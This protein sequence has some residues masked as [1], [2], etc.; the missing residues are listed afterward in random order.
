MRDHRLVIVV[1]LAVLTPAAAARVLAQ[2]PPPGAAAAPLKR[3]LADRSDRRL[4]QRFVEDAAVSSGGWVEMQ[5]RYENLENGSQHLLGPLV[6]FKIVNDVEGGLRFGWQDLN[7]DSGP[8]ESGLSDIDLFGK[9]RFQGRR[10]RAAVGALLKLPKADEAKGLGT[11]RQDVELFG[12]WRADLEA[13]SIVAN[14]AI[15]F[16]G[17]PDPP[18]PPTDNSFLLGGAIL[19]PAS[20]Q[21]TFVIEPTYETERFEGASSD[22]RLTLGFQARGRQG[23]GGLRGAVAVPLSDGAPDYQVI[24]GGFL[25]Y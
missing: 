19:L 22:A 12:A 11:G 16:N 24:V 5:Y 20:P 8:N 13:V 1:F 25:I 9:Y 7:P 21:L 4:F 15:R 23:R 2:S 6:A 3:G 10:A 18:L 14:A 17:N